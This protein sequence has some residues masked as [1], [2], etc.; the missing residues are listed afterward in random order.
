[1]GEEK[2]KKI[3]G[4]GLPYIVGFIGVV[5]SVVLLFNTL[6]AQETSRA[7]SFQEDSDALFR[8]IEEG[9]NDHLAQIQIMLNFYAAS[10]YVDEQEF[11]S[12]SESFM[13]QN[14]SHNAIGF[15]PLSDGMG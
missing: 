6:R 4:T 11:Y 15:I 10:D 14:L 3:F 1:M 7:F 8:L 5:I 9:V 13:T 12:M 2:I